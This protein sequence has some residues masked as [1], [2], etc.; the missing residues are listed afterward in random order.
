MEIES[1]AFRDCSGLKTIEGTGNITS[2][3][4][5]AFEGCSALE[6]IEGT[7]TIR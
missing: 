6:S 1:E 5:Q 4:S 2:I 3:E 7:E